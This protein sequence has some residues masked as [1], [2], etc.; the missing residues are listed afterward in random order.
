MKY[1]EI[2]KKWWFWIILAI[3]SLYKIIQNINSYGRL[4]LA[5]YLGTIIGAFMFIFTI[6][7]I[8]FL[9]IKL[10]NKVIKK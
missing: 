5:G 10:F 7:T 4:F 9:I 2:F 3:L 6:Y 1:K 8:L